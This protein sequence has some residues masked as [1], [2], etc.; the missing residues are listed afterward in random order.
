[1]LP[2]LG[3]QTNVTLHV[4][5]VTFDFALNVLKAD[6]QRINQS[7]NFHESKGAKCIVANFTRAANTSYHPLIHSV[8]HKHSYLL[9]YKMFVSLLEYNNL[10]QSSIFQRIKHPGCRFHRVMVTL[11]LHAL[12]TIF[13]KENYIVYAKTYPFNFIRFFLLFDGKFVCILASTQQ[14]AV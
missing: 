3:D 1:M 2:F 9:T 14:G 13:F 11:K 8:S 5:G 12:Q 10:I 7:I 6:E 4:E